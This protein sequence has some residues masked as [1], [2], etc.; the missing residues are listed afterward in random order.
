[1]VVLAVTGIGF[2]VWGQRLTALSAEGSASETVQKLSFLSPIL[3]LLLGGGIFLVVGLIGKAVKKREIMGFGDVKLMGICGLISGFYGILTIMI[4][5]ALSS[6]IVFAF[7][8]VRGKIKG[9]DEEALGPFI[10]GSTAVYLIFA[11]E[12][13]RLMRLYLEA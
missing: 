9:T 13:M 12:I 3:G 10:A 6:G 2:A 1:V 11:G 4:M 7:L 5:T 8:M